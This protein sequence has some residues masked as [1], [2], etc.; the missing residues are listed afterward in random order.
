MCGTKTVL[1]EGTSLP[2]TAAGPPQQGHGC[3]VPTFAPSWAQSGLPPSKSSHAADPLPAPW[4]CSCG[5]RGC[6]QK[7]IRARGPPDGCHLLRRASLEPLRLSPT[8]DP[9]RPP[10]EPEGHLWA[11][12]RPPIQGREATAP[13]LQ[14]AHAPSTAPSWGSAQTPGNFLNPANPPAPTST[15]FLMVN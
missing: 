8:W 7:D 6:V 12:G 3:R 15:S 14:L 1:R 4:G 11:G 2:A 10:A 13:C 5:L 9:T